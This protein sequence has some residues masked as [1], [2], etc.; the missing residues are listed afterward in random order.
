MRT[1]AA[2]ASRLQGSALPTADDSTCIAKRTDTAWRLA[3]AFQPTCHQLCSTNMV[4]DAGP[5]LVGQP[6]CEEDRS[7]RI[8][9]FQIAFIRANADIP[10]ESQKFRSGIARLTMRPTAKDPKGLETLGCVDRIGVG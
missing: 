10:T 1:A 6:G 2:A 9:R 7:P 4:Q 8:G 3:V 5:V